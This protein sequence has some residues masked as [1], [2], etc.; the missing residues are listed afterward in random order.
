MFQIPHL[1]IF[2]V[3]LFT[4]QSLDF[5]HFLRHKC[6]VRGN[7]TGIDFWC[8]VASSRIGSYNFIVCCGADAVFSMCHLAWLIANCGMAR[9]LPQALI[10]ALFFIEYIKFLYSL[11]RFELDFYSI[12]HQSSTPMTMQSWSLVRVTP[13]KPD[14]LVEVLYFWHSCVTIHTSGHVPLPLLVKVLE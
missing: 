13:S 3:G 8:G 6:F 5:L 10:V 12:S 14:Y 7:S 4:P 9:R 11:Q 1:F 2:H